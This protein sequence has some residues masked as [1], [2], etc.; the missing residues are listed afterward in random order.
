M[1][2]RKKTFDCVEMKR[3]GAEEVLRTTAGMTVE[4]EL[5]YWRRG[6]EELTAQQKAL[7]KAKGKFDEYLHGNNGPR[8]DK[9]KQKKKCHPFADDWPVA[10]NGIQLQPA[11]IVE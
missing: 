7:R 11:G 2:I 10:S 4:E 8:S 5:A 6:T 9:K 1:E 3:K